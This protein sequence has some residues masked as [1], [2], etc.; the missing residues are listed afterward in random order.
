MSAKT[1]PGHCRPRAGA[2]LRR[3]LGGPFCVGPDS[4]VQRF[5]EEGKMRLSFHILSALVAFSTVVLSD[6]GNHQANADQTMITSGQ[7]IRMPCGTSPWWH[8]PSR[9]SNAAQTPALKIP[10]QADYQTG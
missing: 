6:A 2:E 7:H 4:P 10:I 8:R 5:T 1:P 9:T 3:E